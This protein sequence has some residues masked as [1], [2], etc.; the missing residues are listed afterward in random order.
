MNE[1]LTKND[2]AAVSYHL[3]EIENITDDGN[4]DIDPAAM[5][6][7]Q[8]NEFLVIMSEGAGA[9]NRIM[10][11]YFRNLMFLGEKEEKTA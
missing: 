2:L 3:K 10:A 11:N 8:V 1:Y 5:S 4:R 9:L 7:E 6:A